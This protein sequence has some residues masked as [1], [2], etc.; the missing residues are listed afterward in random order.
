[1]TLPVGRRTPSLLTWRL[2]R[3]ELRGGLRSRFRGFRIFLSCLVL[4]TAAIAAVGSV[5]S[6]IGAGLRGDARAL[7][8]GDMEL[9]IHHRPATPAQREWLASSGRISEIVALR[10]MA[11]RIDRKDRRLVELKAVDDSYPLVGNVTLRSGR[12]LV[13]ALAPRGGIH[14]LVAAE[15]LLNRLDLS[16]GDRITIGDAIFRVT[17]VL[18]GEPDRATR[19]I[20]LGPRAIVSRVALDTTRLLKPGALS[21]YYYRVLLRP[22]MQSG[23][24]RDGLARAFPDAPWRVRDPTE[25]APGLTRFINR[26]TLFLTLV[27]LSALLI[28]GIGVGNAV[29]AFLIQRRS[30]IATLKCLGA[31][32]GLV[33]RMYLAQIMLLAALGVAAGLAL[34][35]LSPLVAAPLVSD[36]LPV[37]LEAGIYPRPLVLAAAFGLL[38]TL[39]FSLGPLMLA[40]GVPAAALFRQAVAPARRRLRMLDV[41]V[42]TALVSG[43]AAMTVLT[44]HDKPLAIWFVGGAMA[45]FAAF[46]LAAFAV[47]RVAAHWPRPRHPRLRMALANLHRPGAPTASVVLSLGMGITVLVAIMMIERNLS[48]RIA[49]VVEEQAPAF[50]FIDIQPQQTDDFDALVRSFPEAGAIRQVPMLRGRITAMA[51]VPVSEIEPPPNHAWV[52]RGDRGLTWARTPP[53]SGSHIV[54]GEWWP[55]DY[56][57]PPLISFDAEAAKAYRLKIGDEVAFNILGRQFVAT[58]ANLRRIDWASL[59]M[60]F[61][62]IFSPGALERAPQIRIATVQIGADSEDALEAA[63]NK[64]FPN[65]SAIRV[66]DVVADVNRI[67]K[68]IDVAMKSVAAVAIIAGVLVLSGAIAAG[69]R[70]RIY[71]AVV[72]KTLGATRRDVLTAYLIEFTMLGLVTAAIAAAAGSLAAWAVTT[73]LMHVDWAFTPGA[74]IWTTLVCVAA[75][76]FFGAIGAWRALGQKAAPLLRNE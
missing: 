64:R 53:E 48:E 29:Q 41:A 7:L 21:Q 75:T 42:L 2:A 24:F 18:I 63:V 76:L 35:A 22:G 13:D 1:M 5:S 62:V 72:L 71:D 46:R 49:E 68:S 11:S 50:F 47:I 70:Q 28:G 36:L 17:G 51:G 56:D 69:R 40:R 9:R 65:I 34:G 10:A 57:G 45:T 73:G 31:P 12:S 19:G 39:V 8:G 58:I 38:T 60:N 54:A 37:G 14:G 4:G 52:T 44:A 25:A 23:D 33:L 3:R 66:R 30:T 67:M 59:G 74:M 16:V 32:A 15:S 27:G 6:S 61:V 43:L 55:G 20:Q 26:L